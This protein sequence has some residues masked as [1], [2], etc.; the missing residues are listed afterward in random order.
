MMELPPHIGGVDK[1]TEVFPMSRR[2]LKAD[3]VDGFVLAAGDE[4]R[5]CELTFHVDVKISL[6][7]R[8]ER[9]KFLLTAA[10]YEWGVTEQGVPYAVAEREW[11]SHRAQSLHALLY[12]LAVSISVACQRQ[13]RDDHGYYPSEAPAK[14]G[15]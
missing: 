13:Y 5:E 10:A 4:F 1:H 3:D 12:S 15:Q 14:A 2:Q 7:W 6:K 9:G 8:Q 11:P